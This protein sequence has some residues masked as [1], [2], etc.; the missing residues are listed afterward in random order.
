V[1]RSA[2]AST[3]VRETTRRADKR[4]IKKINDTLNRK[5][6]ALEA[7]DAQGVM[8]HSSAF[9]DLIINGSNNE[10]LIRAMDSIKKL[11]LFYRITLLKRSLDQESTMDEYFKHLKIAHKRHEEILAA[12]ENKDA[13]AAARLMESHLLTTSRDMDAI[14]AA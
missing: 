2:L 5:G 7:R 1:C 3:A 8:N 10:F 11:I 6:E 12:I 13:E 14:F 9:H 4:L